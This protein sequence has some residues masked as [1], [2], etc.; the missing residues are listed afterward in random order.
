MWAHQDSEGV[1]R[2]VSLD[3]LQVTETAVAATEPRWRRNIGK[4]ADS[5][6][7]VSP[8]GT[9]MIPTD[10]ET[11]YLV[12]GPVDAVAV[13]SHHQTPAVA[14]GGTGRPADVAAIIAGLRPHA[15]IICIADGDTP[16]RKAMRQAAQRVPQVIEVIEM[17][18]GFDPGEYY[19][20]RLYA[21]KLG[22]RVRIGVTG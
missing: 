16:G 17:P 7:F 14:C 6:I 18:E 3:S 19:A 5:A 12:E 21:T 2:C 4:H 11:V 9:S 1:V 20:I 15:D 13:S 10:T 22:R 8:A